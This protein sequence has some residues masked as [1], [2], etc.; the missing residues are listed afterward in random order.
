MDN[1]ILDRVRLWRAAHKQEYLELRHMVEKHELLQFQKD[2]LKD[3]LLHAY[4]N[5]PYYHRVF[6]DVGLVR[7]GVV[8]LSR[9]NRVPLLTKDVLRQFSD[10]LIS[11]DYGAGRW[12]YNTSGGSTGEPVRFI[13]DSEFLKWAASTEYYYYRD[14]LG[15]EQ[16]AAKKVLLWGS[17]RDIFGNTRGI[18]AEF[19]NW[20]THTVPLN[21]FRMNKDDI[22]RYIDKINSFKPDLVMGYAGSL[23]ELC[24]YAQ[25]ENIMLHSPKILIS[26]AETLRDEMREVIESSFGTAVNNFYGSRE[27]PFLAAECQEGSMH[28]F[29]FLHLLEVL[30]ARGRPA[31]SG[32]EGKVVVTTLYNYSM[33]LVR[34]EIGDMAIQGDEVCTCGSILPTLKKVTGRVTD[35]FVTKDGTLIH[36]EYFTHLF[37]F[38]DAIKKF[39]V[40]QEDYQQVR[41][42]AV[43]KNSLSEVDKRDIEHKIRLVMGNC[44]IRWDVVDDIPKSPGGKYLYTKSLVPR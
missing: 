33:P 1:N 38:K 26:A 41:I 10:K 9:F 40:I 44:S 36:G 28:I 6:S 39:Q 3:L 42:L 29:S 24:R 31:R 11:K 35:H 21:S 30:D 19:R 15:I 25:N 34:Y 27:A 13:H 7:D 17:E 20:L 14:M 5:V 23:F 8:D 22:K 16:P 2:H 32:Q 18:R 43:L 4:K 12:Y 37:Y